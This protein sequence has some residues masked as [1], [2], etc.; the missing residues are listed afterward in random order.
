[1]TGVAEGA[2]G[3]REDLGGRYREDEDRLREDLSSL[4]VME[5]AVADCVVPSPVPLDGPRLGEALERAIVGDWD[6]VAF[7][8]DI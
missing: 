7:D 4:L 3:E 1:V 6:G 8:D 5:A 2:F